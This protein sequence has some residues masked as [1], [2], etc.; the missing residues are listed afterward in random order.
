LG[1]ARQTARDANH[2]P[3]QNVL[4]RLKTQFVKVF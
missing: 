3:I 2:Y 4:L 1:N